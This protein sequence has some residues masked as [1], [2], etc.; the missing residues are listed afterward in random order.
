MLV[1]GA[2]QGE[3]IVIIVGDEIIRVTVTGSNLVSAKLGSTYTKNIQIYRETIYTEIVIKDQN[4]AKYK[5]NNRYI[6]LNITT[7]T[8]R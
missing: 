7:T 5:D 2:K 1:L 3:S 8:K 4:N 6:I